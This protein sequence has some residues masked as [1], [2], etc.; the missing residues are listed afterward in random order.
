MRDI[1]R[2]EREMI[3]EIKK[4]KKWGVRSGRYK[5]GGKREYVEIK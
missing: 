5:E 4:V 1:R 2:E 3:V